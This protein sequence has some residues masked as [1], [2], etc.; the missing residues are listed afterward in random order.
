MLDLKKYK[1]VV[2][3]CDGVIL[4]SNNIKSKAFEDSLKGENDQLISEFID[5]HKKNGGVSRFLKFEYFFKVLKNQKNYQKDLNIAL[6]KY[7]K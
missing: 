2:F 4:D 7:S 3:D 6:K 1:Q 5:Y